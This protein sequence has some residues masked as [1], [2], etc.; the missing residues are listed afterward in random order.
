MAD[1]T[2]NASRAAELIKCRRALRREFWRG[3]S[4]HELLIDT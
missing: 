2:E 3:Y 1:I 4:P